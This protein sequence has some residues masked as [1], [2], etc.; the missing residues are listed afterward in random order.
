MKL[1][2]MFVLM[3]GTQA[4]PDDCARDKDGV[5]RHKNGVKVAINGDGE[6]ETVGDR[7]AMNSLAAGRRD[8][9]QQPRPKDEQK[10]AAPEP[11]P[12]AD[13]ATVEGQQT[14]GSDKPNE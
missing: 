7:T 11:I 14:S 5:L 12:P 4:D 6:P 1:E 10:P 8:V 2:Q 13:G 3:D 9:E